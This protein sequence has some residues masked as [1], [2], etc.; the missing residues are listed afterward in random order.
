VKRPAAAFGIAG[1]SM[2]GLVAIAAAQQEPG[3]WQEIEEPGVYSQYFFTAVPALQDI[4]ADRQDRGLV[5]F[6]IACW[7]GQRTDVGLSFETAVRRDVPITIALDLQ[8]PVQEIWDAG[9]WQGTFVGVSD[10]EKAI[11]L[12]R[13]LLGTERLTLQLAP[14][15][16][17]ATYTFVMKGIEIPAAAVAERCGWTLNQ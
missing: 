3:T 13:R 6:V 15:G 16:R 1:A 14:H 2:A 5:E 9:E 17:V 4:M 11:A 7:D 10:E 12:I 8:P